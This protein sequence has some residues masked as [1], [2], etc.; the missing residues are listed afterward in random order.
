MR[1]R[2]RVDGNQAEV[3]KA[4]RACGMSVQVL[5]AVGSGCPDLLVGWHGRNFL[6]E[7]KVQRD[8]HSKLEPLTQAQREWHAKWGGS[9]IV[10]GSA[11]NGIT[12]IIHS[13]GV[14]L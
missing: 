4:L 11:E 2:G 14:G 12:Q 1:L 10:A 9:V 8:G 3:V 13:K 7:T 5:S 6:V